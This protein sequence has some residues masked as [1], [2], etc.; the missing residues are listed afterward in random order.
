MV[1]NTTDKSQWNLSQVYL[2]GIYNDCLRPAHTMLSK[3]LPDRCFDYFK[4]A[5]AKLD[6]VF[7]DDEKAQ[8]DQL[9]EDIFFAIKE[10]IVA[11]E[12]ICGGFDDDPIKKVNLYDKTIKAKKKIEHYNSLLLKFMDKYD[13]LLKRQEDKSKIN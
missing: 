5:R 3:N 9:D 8:L 11:R 6:S 1:D 2:F 12:S 13:L 4:L 7:N 10:W